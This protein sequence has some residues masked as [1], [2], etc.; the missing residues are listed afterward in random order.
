[1][2]PSYSHGISP[3][4][5]EVA[6]GV[7]HIFTKDCNQMR[8]NGTV[9][10]MESKEIG[11]GSTASPL[12]WANSEF[13]SRLEIAVVRLNGRKRQQST[14]AAAAAAAAEPSCDELPVYITDQSAGKC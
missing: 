13:V 2:T 4:G 8:L 9:N 7:I 11:I 12:A 10:P 3:V 5:R 1:M 6:N 14:A